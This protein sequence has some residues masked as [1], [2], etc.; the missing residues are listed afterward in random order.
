M[1]AQGSQEGI[2]FPEAELQRGGQLP[3][4]VL[5]R[6]SQQAPPLSHLSMSAL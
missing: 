6:S 2:G 4:A 3:S 1:D 5:W